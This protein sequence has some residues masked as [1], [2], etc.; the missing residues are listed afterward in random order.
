MTNRTISFFSKFSLFSNKQFGFLKNRSTQDA[1]LDFTETIYDALNSRNIN[2][3]ILVDLKSAF[4][5][6]NHDI[7][8]N[9]LELYGIRGQGLELYR[10]YLADRE[11]YVGL[12]NTFSYRKTVNIGIPQGSILGPV[13]FII[14]NNDLPL[15]SKTL[16][17]T[18]FA[19]DTNFS[20]THNDYDLMVPIFNEE[21]N[22]ISNWT[23][24]NRLTINTS[25]TELMLFTNKQNVF[26]DGRV[27]LDGGCL[28]FVDKARF[29]GVQIDNKMSFR[30]HI[31]HVVS[32]VSKHAGY[33]V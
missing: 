31:N 5:T 21:L 19:D 9:K 2:I 28:D 13:L 22:K 4:D 14:Y 23:I 10:S 29:L 24:S 33:I 8:L 11:F 25:K 20:I 27:T 16:N 7:L 26:G 1:L 17:T 30:E 12:Q 3:S 32:K 18:L 15:I 6:V